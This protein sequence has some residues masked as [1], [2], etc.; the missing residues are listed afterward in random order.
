M[1]FS[2]QDKADFLALVQH[3]GKFYEPDELATLDPPPATED[4]ED[5][6][7]VLDPD[8]SGKHFTATSLTQSISKAWS[9]CYM[10]MISSHATHR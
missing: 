6:L 9:M 8:S 5:G 1:P 3:V 7:Y 2:E 10:S 4:T